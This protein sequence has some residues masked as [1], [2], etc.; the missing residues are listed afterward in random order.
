M[1]QFGV[2]KT[3]SILQERFHWPHMRKE[4]KRHCH[5]CIVYLQAKAKTM[6]ND[7]YTSLLIASS[8]WEDSKDF[9]LGLLKTQ[10]VFDSIFVVVDRFSKMAHFISSHKVDIASNICRLFFRD[11]VKLYKFPRTIVF[12][13][14]TKFLSHFW[15]S[16]WSSLG[17]KLQF[18]TSSHPQMDG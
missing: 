12:N 3:L 4:V 18:S 15:K 17:T 14:N 5:K 6:P 11:V 8:L 10:R 16:L 9:I 13:R 1:V 7:L 2:D